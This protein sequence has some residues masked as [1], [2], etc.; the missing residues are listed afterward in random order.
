MDAILR[1]QAVAFLSV[2]AQHLR[3]HPAQIEDFAFVAGSTRLVAELTDLVEGDVAVGD[4]LVQVILVEQI[5]V[6]VGDVG[7]DVQWDA[8]MLAVDVGS[9]PRSLIVVFGN[10]AGGVA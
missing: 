5:L 8:V 3:T 2:V 4:E 7:V 10:D 9:S 6:D 1:E